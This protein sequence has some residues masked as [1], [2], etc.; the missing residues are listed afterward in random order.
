MNKYCPKTWMCFKIPMSIETTV[1]FNK[2]AVALE[3]ELEAGTNLSFVL[4]TWW[5]GE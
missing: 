1:I 2:T 5:P 4:A 3:V